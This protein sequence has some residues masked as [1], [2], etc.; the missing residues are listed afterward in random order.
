MPPPFLAPHVV[1]ALA[2]STPDHFHWIGVGFLITV[3]MAVLFYWDCLTPKRAAR[4]IEQRQRA[5]AAGWRW[6]VGTDDAETLRKRTVEWNCGCV[7][8]V[9]GGRWRLRCPRQQG[10]CLAG[11]VEADFGSGSDCPT[12]PGPGATLRHMGSHQ[13]G[14]RHYRWGAEGH[15]GS[16]TPHQASSRSV[17]WQVVPDVRC[18]GPL[19]RTQTNVYFVRAGSSWTLIDAAWTKDGPLIKEAAEGLFGADACPAAILLT[20]SHP[21]HAGSALQLAQ[22]WKC[23]VYVHSRELPLATGDFSAMTEYAG[24][25]DTWLILP[26]MRAMGRRRREAMLA[27]SN[28]GPV[29]RVLE[30]EAG[31][32]G[33]P[34]W[35]CVP[36]PGHT[37]G[38]ISFF[39]NSDH[40]LITGDAVVTMELNSLSG[41]LRQR[42]GLSEPPWYTTWNRFVAR[43]SIVTLAGLEPTVLAGGHGVPMTGPETARAL[44]HFARS[45]RGPRPS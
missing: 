42:P 11:Q 23:P 20:H 35:Q 8:R 12:S 18:F 27:R 32:P 31:V 9:L 13:S 10:H 25:L 41:L 29:V 36:T 17:P 4:R 14:I 7:H 33:L 38:H 2:S 5:Y 19:G 22:A 44:C 26:I 37:P 21:D 24:P 15:D 34:G 39:R 30:P 1:S 28:L 45:A 6:L 43:E 3:G 16:V 40:V